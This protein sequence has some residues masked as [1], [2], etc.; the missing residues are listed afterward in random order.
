[1]KNISV[2]TGIVLL[3]FAKFL[4]AEEIT[5]DG[6]IDNFKTCQESAVL[7]NADAQFY[8]GAM[9]V[10]GKGVRQ[11]YQ[12][13]KIWFEKA[14]AQDNADAQFLLGTMYAEGQGVHQ[15]Y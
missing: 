12:Q 14:V 4:W 15:D 1:M 9:Y 7:G 10:Q 8:L 3:C 11:D 5:L 13:A 2:L 6:C